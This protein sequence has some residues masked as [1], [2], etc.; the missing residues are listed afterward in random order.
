[1]KRR[2]MRPTPPPFDHGAFWE[3]LILDLQD[4]V[5]REQFIDTTIQ[6]QSDYQTMM[7]AEEL[8]KERVT[9]THDEWKDCTGRK[10]YVHKRNALCDR[11]GCAI[12][13]PTDHIMSDFK[14]FMREDK[15]FLIE[16]ICPHGIGH[17]DPDSARF[18]AKQEGN[19]SI[20]V[21]GCDGCC[22]DPWFKSE[23]FS[24]GN[25]RCT[26]RCKKSQHMGRPE[27]CVA[28]GF[29]EFES[30]LDDF[31]EEDYDLPGWGPHVHQYHYGDD[32]NGHSGSFC[33]CGKEE[34][35]TY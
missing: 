21:H 19:G 23:E 3:D 2:T 35:D 4:P 24:R 18:I 26:C 20:N 6:L 13:N 8:E 34:P 31:E 29:H 9:S 22:R 15:S 17:P 30:E 1:M 10:F 32:D 25:E 12:H 28:H 33:R 7:L 5:F 27:G 11:D 16:R 14:Q